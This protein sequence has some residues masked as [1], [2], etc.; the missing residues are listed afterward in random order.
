MPTTDSPTTGIFTVGTIGPATSSEDA[1]RAIMGR[2]SS[3]RKMRIRL[4][5]S[6]DAVFTALKSGKIHFAVIPH[7]CPLAFS[8]YDEFRCMYMY[9]HDTPG[10]SLVTASVD[11]DILKTA[12][13]LV[14]HPAPM[15]LV[16]SFIGDEAVRAR[17]KIVIADSTAAAAEMASRREV[18]LAITN[19]VAA[20][21]YGLKTLRRHGPIHMC[22]SLFTRRDLDF[23]TFN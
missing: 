9:P 17:L 18:D 16:A 7:A 1:A 15:P 10:Y 5:K 4:F 8:F 20:K 22:W 23:V 21:R 3:G 12:N 2:M 14:T 6:F 11:P 19:D 13:S